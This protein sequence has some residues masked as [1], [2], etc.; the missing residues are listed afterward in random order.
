LTGAKQTV[1]VDL[2]AFAA[3]EQAGWERKAAGYGKLVARIT[4]RVA[5]PRTGRTLDVGCGDAPR[6]IGTDASVAMLRQARLAGS[7]APLVA[8]TAERLPFRD[9]VFDT[10]V[11]AFLLPHLAEPERAVAEFRRVLRPGGRLALATWDVPARTRLVGVLIEA[12]AAAEAP[13][14]SG[15]PAGPPFFRYAQR[16]ELGTLLA[17][18]ADVAIE[19]VAFEHEV[20]DTGE[21]WDGLLDGTVRTAAMITDPPRIRAEFD[22]LAAPYGNKIPV[23]VVVAT[24]SKPDDRR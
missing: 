13:P 11:G 3:F 1:P 23:S 12:I 16:D 10:V 19:T 14:P 21:W 5:L 15:L 22:R 2:E 18:F 20:A 24:A 17:S 4:A 9:A 8:A 7:A 6:G